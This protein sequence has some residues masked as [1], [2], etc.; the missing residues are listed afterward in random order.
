MVRST[1]DMD[2]GE[3]RTILRLGSLK[4][5]RPL[6]RFGCRW[7]DNIKITYGNRF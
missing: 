4:K 3:M 7:E 5:K 6:G 1:E 2:R